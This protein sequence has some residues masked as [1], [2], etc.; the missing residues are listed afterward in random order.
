MHTLEKSQ[1]DNL[2]SQKPR[3]TWKRKAKISQC[4]Q[5][6]GNNK[7]NSRNQLNWTEKTMEK[8]SK[9]KICFLEMISKT[10]KD[11]KRRHNLSI[12]E[13]RQ[14]IS[15]WTLL[16][17]KGEQ[18]SSRNNLI[19]KIWQLKW[20]VTIPQKTQTSIVHSVWNRLFE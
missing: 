1:I 17:S 16:K 13:V 19:H 5:K 3:K 2:I 9:T 6:E 10:D 12:M 18:G 14:W 8:N 15:F 7:N 11:K 20:N 4:K